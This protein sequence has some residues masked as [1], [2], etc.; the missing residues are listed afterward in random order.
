MRKILITL[1]AV[2][3]LALQSM[4]QQS[5]PL[6]LSPMSEDD[7][8][9]FRALP[10]LKIDANV[11][12]SIPSVVDN[13]QL[14]FFR[15]LIAQVGLECGQASSIGVVFNYEMNV[16]RDVPGN[17]TENQYPT[18][19]AY[20]F[21]NGG[22]DAGVSFFETFEILKHVGTPNV[23]DYGGMASGG[24]SRWISG[25][26]NYFNGMHNRIDEVYTVKLNTVEGLQTLKNWIYDHGNGSQYGGVACFYAE[27]AYP[28]NIF[29]PGSPESGKHVLTQWGNSANHAMSI[30][31]YNDYICWDYNNDGR[32]TNDVDLNG[33]GILNISDWEIGGF[34]FA[35][36]YGSISGWGDEGFCYMMY[37]TV[38]DRFGQ[39]GIWNNM[40]AVMKVKDNYR[41]DLA[42]KVNITYPCRNKIKIMLGVSADTNA[43]EPQY[44]LHYP[45]FDY[46]GG[47]V[48]MQGNSG[49]QHLE[50][51]LDLNPLLTYINPDEIAK[52]FLLVSDQSTASFNQGV[53]NSFSLMDYTDINST[54]TYCAQ[55]E[56]PVAVD[57]ITMLTINKSVNYNEIVIQNTSL[58]A[59]ELYAGY[60]VQMQAVGGTQPYKWELVHDYTVTDSTQS[61]PDI[62]GTKLNLGNDNSWCSVD[63]PFGFPFFGETYQ[64]IYPTTEGFL[65]FNETLLPWPYYIEGRTYLIE[66]KMIAPCFAKPFYFDGTTNNGIWYEGNA[67]SCTFRFKMSTSGITGNS[68]VDASV[69]LFPNGEIRFLYGPHHAPDYIH[70]FAGVSAGDGV[71]YHMLNEFGYFTPYG[72]QFTLFQPNSI[73]PG[74]T[75]SRDGFLTGSLT[76][77]TDSPSIKVRVRDIDHISET[78]TYQMAIEGVVMDVQLQSGD[79]PIVE[80]GESFS[81]DVSL[82]NLYNAPTGAGTLTFRS[83]DSNLCIVDSLVEVNSIAELDSINLNDLFVVEVG[84]SYADGHQAECNLVLATENH[85]W[86]RPITVSLRIPVIEI[87]SVV[88]H[89]NENGILEPGDTAVIKVGFQNSGGARLNEVIAH[90]ACTNPDLSIFNTQDDTTSLGQN[91]IW[92][93][94]FG[95][96]FSETAE[97]MQILELQ[98]NLTGSNGFIF[99]KTVPLITSLIL[100]NF[101]TGTWEMF[102]WESYGTAPWLLT[103]DP[104][105][106][107]QYA[108]RSASGM[109]DNHYSVLKLP[110]DVAYPDTISFYMKVS[111]ENN[112][113][114]LK[115]LI[116]SELQAQWSGEIDW[117]HKVFTVPAGPQVFFWNYTKDYSVTNGLDCGL[118]DYVILPARTIPL[119][120]EPQNDSD[121]RMSVFPNPFVN[122]LV[123]HLKFEK[124]ET[125]EL[126]I[127]DM[128]GRLLYNIAEMHAQQKSYRFETVLPVSSGILNIILRTKDQ[129]LVKPVIRAGGL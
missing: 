42:A 9:K 99:S 82:T 45:V 38:A 66:N 58:P 121:M 112:Y 47:C 2:A 113:D 91:G 85:V 5:K 34:K 92:Y 53:I 25:Y 101:E 3:S 24:P 63:L 62:T 98:L 100:E 6:S 124:P 75:I 31:G 106:E 30:V 46:Q 41:P 77:L 67:D 56:V 128:Q 103:I 83:S 119:G 13:S 70:K 11:K 109:L 102:D 17:V 55:S 114:F 29:P 54:E 1:L 108:A 71:N 87:S 59:L 32:F 89:D 43:T 7:M 68:L 107:G 127:I 93:A 69:V 115:F 26:D 20:N 76:E 19:F 22:S 51:G 27:F 94:E 10:E 8:Q 37:K 129:I 44:I 78:Q 117:Q 48:A 118:I 111:S 95:V 40:A 123:I 57:Q 86:T 4:A 122:Q 15:P 74:L 28:P 96:A 39:G 65:M 50:L 36:T 104:V 18:H 80:F 88:V 14:S 64:K 72:N 126:F 60:E 79:D 16:V 21:I 110:W 49:E 35:N 23:A 81:A 105:Y 73:F 52:F 84:T 12:R 33:D 116:N 97:P 90:L 61:Y 120:L 125:F